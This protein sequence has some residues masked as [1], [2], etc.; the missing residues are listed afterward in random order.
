VSNNSLKIVKSFQ[1]DI[2]ID[3]TNVEYISMRYN[4]LQVHYADYVK[5]YIIPW[6][7]AEDYQKLIDKLEDI[8]K[9]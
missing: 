4:E 6:L 2:V 7:T 9:K 5:T 1:R 8:N 3:L